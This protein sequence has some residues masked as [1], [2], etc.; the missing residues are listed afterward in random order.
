MKE[1]NATIKNKMG[2]HCR[3]SAIIIKTISQW[4]CSIEADKDGDSKWNCIIEVEKDGESIV[5]NTVFD[6]MGLG[7]EKGQV[8]TIRAYGD[9][10]DVICDRMV[11]LFETEFDFEPRQ[12]E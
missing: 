8:I 3:P 4:N 5:L 10:A 2:I 12:G 1:R 7:L 9:D 6:L 11:T